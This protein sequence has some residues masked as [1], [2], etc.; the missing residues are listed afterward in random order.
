MNHQREKL[1]SQLQNLNST[2]D[3]IH[4]RRP[5]SKKSRKIQLKIDKLKWN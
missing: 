2:Q 5:T 3:E 4:L 1:A